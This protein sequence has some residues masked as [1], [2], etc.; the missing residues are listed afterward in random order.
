[1]SLF[2][3][4]CAQQSI[5]M[6]GYAIPTGALVGEGCV[7]TVLKPS[8]ETVIGSAASTSRPTVPYIFRVKI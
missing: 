2:S 8:D 7:W 4:D 6:G 5:S 1:M 3:M